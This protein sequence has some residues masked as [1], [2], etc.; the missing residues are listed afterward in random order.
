MAFKGFTAWSSARLQRQRPGR[1]GCEN[2]S[3]RRRSGTKKRGAQAK[4][5][6][7]RRTRRRGAATALEWRRVREEVKAVVSSTLTEAMAVAPAVVLT[8]VQGVVRK[9][10]T[11][12]PAP[13]D[14]EHG[15]VVPT[16]SVESRTARA[17]RSRR[18]RRGEPAPGWYAVNRRSDQ[19]VAPWL[20]ITEV[21]TGAVVIG[22]VGSTRRGTLKAVT[23][24][25]RSTLS[26]S[27]SVART[28]EEEVGRKPVTGEPA[29]GDAERGAV[30]PTTSA[31]R[32][33]AR[34]GRCRRKATRRASTWLVR[35]ESTQ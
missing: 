18:R 25:V 11:G 6:E 27:P 24:E 20:D 10:L 19:T 29:P 8:G 30:V 16:T 5:N 21:L 33:T 28:P 9:P 12:E 3:P 15:A 17:K 22:V 35:S 4:G 23:A 7:R 13:G 1:V 2:Q 26:A 34:A 31:A 32:R 14:A